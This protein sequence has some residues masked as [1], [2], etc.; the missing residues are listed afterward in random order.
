MK[1]KIMGRTI[2]IP[3]S[4]V[5]EYADIAE[6][7]R[8]KARSTAISPPG[9][10]KEDDKWNYNFYLYLD[11]QRVNGLIRW[12]WYEPFSFWLVPPDKQSKERGVRHKVDFCIWRN[13]GSIEMVE[14][15][16]RS[17]RNFRDGITRYKVAKDRF[18]CFTWKIVRL[19]NGGWEEFTV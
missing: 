13:D 15:K 4:R 7:A 2:E 3:D 8:N 14:V 10:P 11:K 6:P 9:W 18:P 17:V 12:F 19:K 1:A 16:G 5:K